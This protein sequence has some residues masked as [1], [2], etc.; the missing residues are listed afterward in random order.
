MEIEGYGEERQSTGGSGRWVGGF[1]GIRK[2]RRVRVGEDG[3][4]V[5][6]YGGGD[7][8]RRERRGEMLG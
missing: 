6:K 3:C 8:E 1:G 7:R 5:R 2:G 4:K